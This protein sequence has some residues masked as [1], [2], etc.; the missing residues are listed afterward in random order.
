[1][2]G[3]IQAPTER[4]L[5]V[6]VCVSVCVSLLIFF[7]WFVSLGRVNDPL[8]EGDGIPRVAWNLELKPR[9]GERFVRRRYGTVDG[10]L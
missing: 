6:C 9:L 1:M 3:G 8:F 5:D 7:L 2:T 4:V 10:R